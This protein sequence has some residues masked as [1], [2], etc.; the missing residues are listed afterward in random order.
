MNFLVQR[1]HVKVLFECI[2]RKRPKKI[3]TEVRGAAAGVLQR[4][5]VDS[6]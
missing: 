4:L 5:S 3:S 2:A 6:Q 1:I